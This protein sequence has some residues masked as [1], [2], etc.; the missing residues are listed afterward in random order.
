MT[1]AS[2]LVRAPRP[3]DEPRWRQLWAAYL[4][5]YEATVPDDATEFTLRRIL[6]PGRP[7][8][9][10][11][12]QRDGAMIGFAICVLHEG[13]WDVR[14]TCYLEDLFVDPAARGMGVGRA[15]LDDLVS[16]GAADGW[17]SIYWH[18]RAGNARARGLYD[19]YV[20]AD[21]FVRYRLALRR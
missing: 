3:G 21:E 17:A 10:R 8:F 2:I 5:F 12:A 1:R 13:T 7:L 6:D 11:V 20:A 15:L 9:G 19:R 16:L 18:T 4:D 14:P